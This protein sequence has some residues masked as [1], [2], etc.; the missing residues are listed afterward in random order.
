[1]KRACGTWLAVYLLLA[2]AAGAITYRRFPIPGAAAGAAF[3][4]GG[5]AWMGVAYFAGIG[6]KFANARMIKRGLSGDAPRDG[7][8][9]AAVGRISPN[10]GA[11]TSPL[12]KSSCVAYKFEIRSGL[13]DDDI[14]YYEGFALTPGMVQGRQRSVRLLAWGDL[15]VPWRTIPASVAQ[16]NAEEYIRETE[17]REP[18]LLNFRRSIADMAAIYKDDDGSIRW[19]QRGLRPPF[20]V[21]KPIDLQSATYREMLLKPGDSVCVIG[22]YSAQ[23]GGIIP[24]EHPMVDPVTVEVGEPEVFTRR[25][26]SGAVGYFIG[27]LI[28]SAIFVAALV[29]LHAFVPLAASEQMN[30]AMVAS[31][32]EIRL[33]RLLDTR[34]RPRMHEAGMLSDGNVT[35]TLRPGSANGRVRAGGRDVIVSRAVAH[36][37][38]G[39]TTITVDDGLLVLTIDQKSRPIRLAMAGR[40]VSIAFADVQ[41]VENGKD[42]VAGRVI[43]IS[44]EPN[45]PACRVTFSSL[46]S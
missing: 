7:A 36:R 29:A 35:I 38:D 22:R 6:K 14:T 37:S 9:I 5:V 17:F 11:L 3:I 30:P 10:G 8:K 16:P 13:S 4:G 2:A 43:Y 31:W 39:A 12:S 19:D 27:G 40:E 23:R 1:M 46:S 21:G 41:I 34:V 33:E 26:M 25:A 15:K 20:D 28:F 42:E 44:D 32:P 18:T 24:S 45:G